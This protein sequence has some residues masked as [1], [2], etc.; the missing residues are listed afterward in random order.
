MTESE[1]KFF[2]MLAQS[3]EKALYDDDL[4]T[5]EGLFKHGQD[6]AAKLLAEKKAG[7][8]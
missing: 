4:E 3:I 5:L 8:K 1:K 2:E 6:A 7:V